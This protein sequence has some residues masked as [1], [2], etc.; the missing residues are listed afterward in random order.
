MN[1]A[2]SKAFTKVVKKLSGKVLESVKL[3]ITEVK[4]VERIDEI[5]DCKKLVG[6][7]NVYRKRIGDLRAFMLLHIHIDG[8]TIVFEY[9][10]PRGQAYNKKTMNNLRNKDN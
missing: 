1:I 8:N 7:N 4:K 6:F 5:S 9:L 10:I 3:A 2:Y